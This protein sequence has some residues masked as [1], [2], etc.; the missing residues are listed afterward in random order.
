LSGWCAAGEQGVRGECVEGGR[1]AVAAVLAARVALPSTLTGVSA[2]ARFLTHGVCTAP[3]LIVSFLC[4]SSSALSSHFASCT[5]PPQRHSPI[6]RES[7]SGFPAPR[8]QLPIVRASASVCGLSARL[9]LG[10]R[11]SH[12]PAPWHHL[13][14]VPMAIQFCFQRHLLRPP[15]SP[16]LPAM[17]L[18]VGCAPGDSHPGPGGLCSM[19]PPPSHSDL[20]ADANCAALTPRPRLSSPFCVL[21]ITFTAPLL[22]CRPALLVMTRDHIAQFC[23]AIRSRG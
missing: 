18:G 1:G 20:D 21:L 23:C 8:R 3:L 15:L 7:A 11:H 14:I 4:F 22:D 5:S 12:S 6:V 17:R 9:L 10:V 13:R 19:R 2:L 16:V